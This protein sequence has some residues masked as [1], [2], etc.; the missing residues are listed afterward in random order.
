LFIGG[1]AQIA[2]LK[3]QIAKRN[4]ENVQFHGYQPRDVLAESLSVPHVHLISL[5]PALEGLIVP[6]KFYGIAAAGRASIFIGRKDGE[7]ARILCDT[8]AGQ[9]VEQ[10]AGAELGRMIQ[11]MADDP[12]LVSAWA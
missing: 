6:S 12:K 9:V 11:A 10:G 1:G 7:L 3:V 5:Q 4:L 8:Y 2:A